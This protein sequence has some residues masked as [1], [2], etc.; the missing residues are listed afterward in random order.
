MTFSFWYIFH[1]WIISETS[2]VAPQV[3][4]Y[5]SIISIFLTVWS[6]NMTSL[7]LVEN[8]SKYTLQVRESFIGCKMWT[9][10]HNAVTC[11]LPCRTSSKLLRSTVNVLIMV[12]NDVKTVSSSTARS[13]SVISDINEKVICQMKELS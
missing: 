10:A 3:Q 6:I 7:S 13:Q 2:P 1:Q 4:Q 8:S 11:L 9:K 12:S 5:Y